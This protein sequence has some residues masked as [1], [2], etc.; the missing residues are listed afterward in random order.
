[1]REDEEAVVCG[2]STAVCDG[3]LEGGAEG[4]REEGYGCEE[5]VWLVVVHFGC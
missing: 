1:M 4:W 2:E 5:V 3:G